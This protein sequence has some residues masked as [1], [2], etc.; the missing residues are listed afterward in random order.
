ML[1]SLRAIGVLENDAELDN[2]DV[3]AVGGQVGGARLAGGAE[4]HDPWS[5]TGAWE[6]SPGEFARLRAA[7]EQP[8]G[9]Y[10]ASEAL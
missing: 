6:S 9:I 10:S 3:A 5:G 2:E 4:A 8:P 1:T 7:L